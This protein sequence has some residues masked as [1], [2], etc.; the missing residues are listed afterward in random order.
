MAVIRVRFKMSLKIA[1]FSDQIHIF[2]SLSH[3][4]KQIDDFTLAIFWPV[5]L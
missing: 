5:V 2:Q 3:N 4:N 1:V